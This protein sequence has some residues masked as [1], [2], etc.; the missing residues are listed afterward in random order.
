MPAVC[1]LDGLAGLFICD[2]NG[3]KIL[4]AWPPGPAA[5]LRAGLIHLTPV[6]AEEAG[7]VT[8]V[9]DVH[10]IGDAV[11]AGP[12]WL[13]DASIHE[14]REFIVL[15]GRHHELLHGKA[16]LQGQKAAHEVSE[17]AAGHREDNLLA[18]RCHARVG[19]EVIDCLG[20]QSA[21]IDGIG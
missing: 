8:G 12:D 21:D 6:K 17:V 11:F 4:F 3:I 13:V 16:H 7:K 14:A 19:I 20:Q 1:L 18:L 5:C 10:G 15:I 2:A 9:A